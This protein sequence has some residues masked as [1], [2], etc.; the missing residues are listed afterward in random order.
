M[1]DKTLDARMDNDSNGNVHASSR[2]FTF[3]DQ[4]NRTR[5]AAV[6]S[7]NVVRSHVM[8][9]IRRLKRFKPEIR[10][11]S[12]IHIM[13]Q[14]ISSTPDEETAQDPISMFDSPLETGSDL[15]KP[16][17]AWPVNSDEWAAA[18]ITPDGI[19]NVQYAFGSE[20]SPSTVLP[21]ITLEIPIVGLDQGSTRNVVSD[22][23]AVDEGTQE[24]V[25]TRPGLGETG[26][27][28]VSPTIIGLGRIDP[29][30]ALPIPPNREI[31]QL[32]DHCKLPDSGVL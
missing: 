14:S 10:K 7:Q 18:I 4:N 32:V 2:K 28:I 16:F 20:A 1:D 27:T 21:P 23:V 29:F 19:Q 31:Y 26:E 12:N 24:H 25:L 13:A 9:E 6:A 15:A 22:A 8:T 11:E 30:R 17:P 5:E 3:V